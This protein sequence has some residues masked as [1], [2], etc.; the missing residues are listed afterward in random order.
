MRVWVSH[1]R[2]GGFVR[3]WVSH[4]R[5]GGFMRVPGGWV[6]AGRVFQETHGGLCGYLT[7]AAMFI[8]RQFILLP[9]AAAPASLP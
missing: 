2:H 4:V 8:R 7:V 6:G 3:V 9:F 5:H 1:V